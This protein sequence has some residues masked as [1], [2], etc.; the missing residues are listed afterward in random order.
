M[1]RHRRRVAPQQKFHRRPNQPSGAMLSAGQRHPRQSSPASP[2]AGAR[3]QAE[4]RERRSPSSAAGEED[5]RTARQR[6]PRRWR[7]SAQPP[8]RTVPIP[9]RRS[10]KARFPL[11]LPALR[12]RI[13]LLPRAPR[14]RIHA[15]ARPN[16]VVGD[17]FSCAQL[18]VSADIV[19]HNWL[20]QSPKRSPARPRRGAT[21]GRRGLAKRRVW[22][23]I[24]AQA[25]A[26]SRLAQ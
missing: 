7:R 21:L 20:S 9:D 8:S 16:I 25:G 26:I 18:L 19:Q 22:R 4:A 15:Q 23:S 13:S 12:G 3:A 5:P 10:G 14:R 2:A 1:P 6:T 24:C 11:L 17:N